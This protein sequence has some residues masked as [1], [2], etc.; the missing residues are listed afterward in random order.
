MLA[1]LTRVS[2]QLLIVTLVRYLFVYIMYTHY[3]VLCTMEEVILVQQDSFSWHLK[4]LSCSI[5]GSEKIKINN[6][7]GRVYTGG[8]TFA[9]TQTQR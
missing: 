6:K 9:T 2:L 1:I 7:K 8:S 4:V 3:N 5:Y